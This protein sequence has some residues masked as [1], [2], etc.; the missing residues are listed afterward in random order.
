MH[1]RLTLVIGGAAAGKS[2]HAERMVATSGLAPV[3][4]AT[5]QALDDEMHTKIGIHIARRGPDWITHECPLDPAPVL[6]AM[7][8]AQMVLFDCAT[9]WLSNVLLADR[10]LDCVQAALLD[11][12]QTCRAPLVVVSNEVGLGIV[13]DNALARRFREAQGR[14]NIEL[15]ARADRVVQVVAGLPMVL[16]G[17][18]P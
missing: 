13:P 17:N 14:L 2:V 16:K 12:M 7:T 1:P 18:D 6:A 10:D 3:Y 5:A 15:A 4:I 11:A 8:P 9:L